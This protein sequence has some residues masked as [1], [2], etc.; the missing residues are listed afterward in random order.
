[1]AGTNSDPKASQESLLSVLLQREDKA[2][3]KLAY[4]SSSVEPDCTINRPTNTPG[5]KDQ[6]Q[7]PQKQSFDI[8][9]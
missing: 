7:Q 9:T 5:K 3:V 6:L 2:K 8:H 1:M 4:R